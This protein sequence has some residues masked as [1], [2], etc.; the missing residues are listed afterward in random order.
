MERKD[1]ISEACLGLLFRIDRV[2]DEN[3]GRDIRKNPIGRDRD[4]YTVNGVRDG[5]KDD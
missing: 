3:G 4:I 5:R 1:L 2:A